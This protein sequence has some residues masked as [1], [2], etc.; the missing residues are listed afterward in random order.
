MTLLEIFPS[1]RSGM[2]SSRLDA[3]VWP[4]ETHYDDLGR[5][6]IG[7]VALADIADQYGTPAYVLD[8]SEVRR[9]CRA[10]RKY[11]PDAEIIYAAKAL[12]TKSVAAWVAEEGLSVDVCSAGELAVA[13]AAGVD[14]QRIVLHGSGKP[15]AELEAAVHAGVGRIV[16]DSITEITLL[17]A[18]VTR[19]QQVLLRLSPDIDVHG[20]PAVRTGVADQKFGFPLGSAAAADAID[21]I[22]R[23]PMLELVGLHCHLGSQIYDPDFYGEAVRRLITEMS[24]VREKYGR[25][26]PQL[27]LGGGHAV[28][29]RG[30][31]AEMNLPELADIVEDSLDAACALNHCPRPRISMEPGRAIVARAG[32]TLYRVMAVKHIE[33]GRTFVIADGGMNDNPRVALYGAQYDAVVANRHPT[34]PQMIATVAGRYCEAGDILAAGVAL[35][36]DLR[37]GEV[38]AVPCTGAYHHSLASTYN[39]VGRPPIISVRNGRCHEQIRRETP[40]DLLARDLG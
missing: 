24:R 28:A 39:G 32:V 10:Y 7:G 6:T 19:P 2:T 5:I 30:G 38:L 40:A 15:F 34:G 22:M 37:P 1:L 16:V 17:A 20:H 14:P 35:P 3:T 9:R 25:P 36:A 31:D 12:L 4:C 11:F 29:Y 23:Q 8:E 21:R 33:G 13:M 18:V 26:L 27:D